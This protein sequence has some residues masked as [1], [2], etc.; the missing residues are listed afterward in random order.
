[1]TADIVVVLPRGGVVVAAE[2]ALILRCSLG[3]L[4]VR[5]IGHPGHREFA[6]G[7]L[8]EHGMMILDDEAIGPDPR[9]RAELEEVIREESERLRE[10]QYKFHRGAQLEFGG[11]SVLLVDDGL[12]TGLTTEAAALSVRKLGALKIIIAAP[13]ASTK[14]LKRVGRVADDAIALLVDPDF[15]A[16]GS[17][18]KT[19]PET[20][21]GE[22]VELLEAVNSAHSICK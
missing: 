7:A 22:V 20:S 1:V 9:V 14:A 5:K 17:Y 2:V 4:V 11:K 8:A 19:F 3:V 18:Y 6:V 12:A 13:V 16:V 15:D 10:Y 21:I